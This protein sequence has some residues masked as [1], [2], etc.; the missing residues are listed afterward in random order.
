MLLYVLIGISVL[1]LIIGITMYN[2]L[3][4]KKNNVEYAFSSIDVML[5]KRH[6]LIPNLV[7]AVKQ[8]MTHEREL[9][10]QITALRTEV[11]NPNISDEQRFQ[12][13][14]KLSS[15]LG[16]IQVA[17]E[18]YPD[19]KANTNFLQLQAAMNEVE[20]QI[21]ASRRAFNASVNH[22][23]NSVEMF[24]TNIVAGMMS[25]RRRTSFE[26]AEV[27]RANVDVNQLFGN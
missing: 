10:T 9:L 16:K 22:Y 17:V 21:S 3:I 18:N 13:E 27:E 4:A 15:M 23:N 2:G 1:L 5:K 20:E 25:L 12:T 7:A 6:D 14:G 24:P 19:L 11:M 26:I 8:Y